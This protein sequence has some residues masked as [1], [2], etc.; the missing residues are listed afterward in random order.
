MSQKKKKKNDD[1]ININSVNLLYLH[2]VNASGYI[3]EIYED[4]YLV[5][6][7]WDEN[8]K[9]LKRYGD[10]FNGIMGKI[11]EIDDGYYLNIQKIT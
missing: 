4:K 7:V 2:I 8:K 9:L 5:F 3:E 11:K 1:C 6:D 10:V